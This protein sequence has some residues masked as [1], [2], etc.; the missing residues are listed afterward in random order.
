MLATQAHAWIADHPQTNAP[1]VWLR[2]DCTAHR[3]DAIDMGTFN[4]PDGTG[5]EAQLDALR[6]L[7][8]QW[9]RRQEDRRRG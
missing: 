2:V 5:L 9:E 8:A 3:V 4:H 1:A 6:L 7:V